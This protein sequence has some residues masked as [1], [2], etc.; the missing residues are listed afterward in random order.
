MAGQMAS[1]IQAEAAKCSGGAIA[2]APL[3]VSAGNIIL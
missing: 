3:V 1:S 2:P